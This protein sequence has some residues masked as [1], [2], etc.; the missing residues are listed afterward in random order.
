MKKRKRWLYFFW[1]FTLI[2]GF[3]GI[4]NLVDNLYLHPTPFDGI[5]FGSDPEQ[6][7]LTVQYVVPGSPAEKAGVQKGDKLLAINGK[8]TA[9]LRD[10]WQALLKD[11]EPGKPAVY[12]FQRSGEIITLQLKPTRSWGIT[13]IVR[14][15]VGLLFLMVGHIVAVKKPT[16]RTARLYYYLSFTFFLILAFG[17][18]S[19][20][21]QYHNAFLFILL[22]GVI[23]WGPALLHFFLNFPAKAP[24]LHKFPVISYLIYLP[25]LALT[26]SAFFLNRQWD[27][28]L[29]ILISLYITASFV[30]LFRN[31][32]R[33][34]NLNEKRSLR[35]II[36]GMMLA[37][38]PLGI[39]SFFQEL[40]LRMLGFSVLTAVFILMAFF[41]IAF[42]YAIMRYGLMDIEIII[43]KSLT[44]SLV[45]SAVILS[46][47]V[48]V[49]GL[50]NWLSSKIAISGYATS[51]G[52]LAL[53]ALVFQPV[54]EKIQL[55]VD[56]HFYRTRYEYQKTLLSLSQELLRL[57]N[58]RDIM[59]KVAETIRESMHVSA[60]YIHLY[61]SRTRRYELRLA[62]PEAEDPNLAWQDEPNGL[63]DILK[64][65]AKPCMF[66]KIEEDDRYHNLPIADKVKIE[67]NEILLSIP[68][69]Y[70]K[71]LMGLIN[72]GPKLSGLTYTQEDIDLLQTVAGN[73]AVALANARLYQEELKKQRLE[74][75]LMI[76]RQI[77]IS[78][79]PANAPNLPGFEITGYSQPATIVGGDYYDFLPISK[80][81]AYVVLGDV[82]GKGMPAALYM[83][84]VQG[85][86]QILARNQKS[87]RQLLI[88]L[89]R[90]IYDRVDHRYFIT[91]LAALVDGHRRKLSVCRAGHMP[92]LIK[93]G[94]QLQWI[95][96]RGMGLGL[97]QGELFEKELEETS[98]QLKPG[99][100]CF[101]FSDGLI[102]LRN[103]KDEMY[104]EERLAKLLQ[105]INASSAQ[106]I[107]VAVQEELKRFAGKNQQ[108]DDI[109][110]IVILAK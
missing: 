24:V 16:L 22:M 102:E 43:R 59:Q 30:L 76:A 55:F 91:M 79:L 54:R 104:G 27:L 86:L 19:Y 48:L 82:A 33:T 73:T 50:G 25:S 57:V 84:K 28:P 90:Q 17:M 61:N 49:V 1:S 70:Q 2:F 100:F 7:D 107:Q 35:V 56:R 38:V 46:Y 60:V 15:F 39:L 72:L 95:E 68:L 103:D 105:R 41:P 8:E 81:R 97:D 83:S 77:Q 11:L 65:E 52:F 62:L 98:F 6:K 89:N 5:F 101:F 80:T 78:L 10:H 58:A 69:F 36:W 74:S 88:E 92:F 37:L 20:K 12:R 96:S 106:E 66:H 21:S 18:I 3:L 94:G 42:G 75:E 31:Y 87:A 47:L 34:R 45:T 67:R 26:V 14:I 108:P 44:Y 13:L 93:S 110:W 32:A 64:R 23:L 63:V 9:K 71:S 109:T 4:F 29:T 85:M 51:M 99:D 53:L 40:A